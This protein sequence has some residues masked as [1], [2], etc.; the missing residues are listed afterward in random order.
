[1]SQQQNQTITLDGQTYAVSDLT[2]V[3]MSTVQS[4]L[5]AEMRIRELQTEIAISQAAYLGFLNTLKIELAQLS[6]AQQ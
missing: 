5:F 4:L 2:Q 1:M 6:Q 3:A